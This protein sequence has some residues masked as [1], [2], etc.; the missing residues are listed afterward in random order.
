M[1]KRSRKVFTPTRVRGRKEPV[2]GALLQNESEFSKFIKQNKKIHTERAQSNLPA[3][4]HKHMR[5]LC[6]H[7]LRAVTLVHLISCL[8]K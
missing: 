2:L 8:E 1:M 3:H 6:A 7:G 4:E 5:G